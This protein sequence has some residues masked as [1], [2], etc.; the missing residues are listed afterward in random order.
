MSNELVDEKKKLTFSDVL[1]NELVANEKALPSNFNQT[2]FVQN[3]VAL[4]N[5]NETLAKFAQQYGTSQIKAGLMR[6]AYLGL[7]ALN[8]ECHLIPYGNKI[9]FIV[10]W[11]GAEKLCRK[12]STRPIKEMYSRV[13]RQGD[14]LIEKIVDGKPSIDFK[15]LPFNDGAIIGAFAVCIF[16]DDSMIY[17]TMSLKELENT[18]KQSKASNSPA[19]TKFTAEMYRK[20]VLRRLCKHITLDFENPEQ[21]KNFNDDADLPM[22]SSDVEVPDVIDAVDVVEVEE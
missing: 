1:K 12:Y 8:S 20:T 11:R 21:I 4:L 2:R 15:P 22:E 16:S 9:Q 3:A 10:D 18:R 5:G 19:W 7:D 17:D 14:E 6:G 13:V